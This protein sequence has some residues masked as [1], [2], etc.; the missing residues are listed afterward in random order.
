MRRARRWLTCAALAASAAAQ[1]QP[2]QMDDQVIA[3][4]R[5]SAIPLASVEAGSGFEDLEPL[6]A[7]M[8]DAHLVAL[9][10]ATHGTAEFFQMKH[11][12]L[13]YLVERKGFR[14]FAIEANYPECEAIN[15]YVRDGK[16]D[17][18]EA[19][20]GQRFWTWDT[21]EVLALIQWMR[22]YNADPTHPEKLRFYGFDMQFAARGLEVARGFLEQTGTSIA[23]EL[24]ARLAPFEDPAVYRTYGELPA[25]QKEGMRTAAAE[26]L[27]ALD[28]IDVGHAGER[29]R[30]WTIAR[31]HALV[32]VQAEENM[33]ATGSLM[34]LIANGEMKRLVVGI[35]KTSKELLKFFA[36]GGGQLPEASAAVLETLAEAGEDG[37]NA[38][39]EELSPDQRSGWHDAA[40]RIGKLVK[41]A[42]A[43]D[44]PA[45]SRERKRAQRRAQFLSDYVDMCRQLHGF[46]D[47]HE[48]IG[49]VRDRCMAENVAWI[50][51]TEGPETKIVL[52]AHNGHISHQPAEPGHG[53]MGTELRRRY[54]EDYFAL[55]FSFDRGS[56]Q[57][58]SMRADG[59][60]PRL[61]TFTVGA[62]PADSIDG[63]FAR[64][65]L[66]LFAVG[67]RGAPAK[68]APWLNAAHPMRFV[69]AAYGAEQPDLNDTVLAECYDAVI[70][71]AETT[72]ARPNRRTRE[73]HGIK[74]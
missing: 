36:G 8:G 45:A 2:S 50:R 25:A 34:P 40:E 10:E 63:V 12:L 6:G 5:T 52:W 28:Q 23:P 67:L 56:F 39:L 59:G 38:Y 22:R 19:L 54:G 35:G 7:L 66:P 62:A 20:H 42:P 15:S 48:S 53:V 21:E 26:L 51:A 41:D 18:E 29:R 1:T 61:R 47:K 70:F 16:G 60:K 31:Q 37:V 13:E 55:A 65:G 11:R 14:V 74:R 3:W 44:D 64:V 69:G 71:M 58:L 57:A 72:R 9:G 24:G 4:L 73:K 30:G 46:F 32:V 17:P 49:E 68:V 43:S 33:R 27:A